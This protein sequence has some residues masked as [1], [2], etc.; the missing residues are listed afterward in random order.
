MGL[1]QYTKTVEEEAANIPTLKFQS[2][3]WTVAHLR[4]GEMQVRS[5]GFLNEIYRSSA[6]CI[7]HAEVVDNVLLCRTISNLLFAV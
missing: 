2:K 4:L 3:N 1:A 5:T 6:L 7:R